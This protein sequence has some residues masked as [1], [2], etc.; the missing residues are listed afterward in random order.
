MSD[1]NIFIS[2][3]T[4]AGGNPRNQVSEETKLMDAPNEALLR[5]WLNRAQLMD[6][7]ARTLRATMRSAGVQQSDRLGVFSAEAVGAC[8]A[9]L[10]VLQQDL[11]WLVPEDPG[12]PRGRWAENATGNE[13]PTSNVQRPKPTTESIKAA[14]ESAERLHSLT[15]TAACALHSARHLFAAA[16]PGRCIEQLELAREALRTLRRTQTAA[17]ENIDA[18]LASAKP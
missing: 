3:G 11:N 5:T 10:N 18:A 9:L 15:K 13:R 2:P 4:S 16:A 8:A 6:S 17:L 14:T 1:Q 12:N 7:Q